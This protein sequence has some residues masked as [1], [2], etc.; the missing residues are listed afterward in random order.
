MRGRDT[1]PAPLE[2]GGWDGTFLIGNERFVMF[3]FP[4]L[5]GD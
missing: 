4:L 3:L 1:P 5:R 2:R